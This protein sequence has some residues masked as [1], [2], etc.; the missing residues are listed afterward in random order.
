LRVPAGKGAAEPLAWT[1]IHLI[2]EYA[3][4]KGKLKNLSDSIGALI[5]Q[6]FD[7]RITAIEQNVSAIALDE[8]LARLLDVQPGTPGLRVDRRY[9]GIVGLP[10]EYVTAIHPAA[11][12]NLSMRL[13]RSGRGL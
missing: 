12:F 9:L 6:T 2:E 8:T 7:D 10:F 11:R 5:E 3:S 4:I 1:R 13:D